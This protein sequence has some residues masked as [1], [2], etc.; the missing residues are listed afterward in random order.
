MVAR[1]S[2][3]VL[4]LALGVG[5]AGCSGGG[6]SGGGA[7]LPAAAPAPGEPAAPA[8]PPG[9]PAAPPPPVGGGGAPALTD[10]ELRQAF[11]REGVVAVTLAPVETASLVNLGEALFY[12]KLLSG[13]RNISCA[14]CHH[15]TAGTGDGLPLPLGEGATGQTTARVATAADQVIARNGPPLFHVGASGVESMF[16]DSRVRRDDA[17]GVLTTPEPVLNGTTPA[18]PDLTAQLTSALAAQAMFPVTSSAEMRGDPGENELADAANNEAVWAGIMARLVGTSNGTVGGVAAYRAL[19]QA[20]FPTVNF[21]LMTFAHGARAIAAFEAATWARFESPFDQFL[22][23][24]DG[25]LS[26]SEKR[27]AALFSG[28]ARCADCHSGPLLSDFRHHSIA[29]PQLGPGA[30]GEPDDRGRALET[31]DRRDDY[32]FRTPP[33]RNVELTAPY[34]HAGSFA[35]L[36]DTIRHYRDPSDSLLDYQPSANLPAAFQ[37]L[38]DTDATR[39]QARLASVDRIVGNGIRLS[40][41]EISDLAAFLRALTDPAARTPVAPPASVPSGLPVAD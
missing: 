24:N 13:N 20:A 27:G 33:L 17:T 12:D 41:A 6:S 28:R 26:D 3:L 40:P 34:F 1:V 31:G 38:V 22:A 37:A 25:A 32:Q 14:T 30:G 21:D 8:P 18:R 23:G 7:A 35:S 11:A 2:V 39:N 4:S 5:V 10:A 29:T 9:A 16:W 19:F 15:P 36:E